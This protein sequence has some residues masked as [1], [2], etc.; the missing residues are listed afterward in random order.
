MITRDELQ[1]VNGLRHDRDNLDSLLRSFES[2]YVKAEVGIVCINSASKNNT[3]P[4]DDA[5]FFHNEMKHIVTKLNKLAL[6]ELKH[7]LAKVELE[8]AK[9]IGDSA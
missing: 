8:I 6:K 9:Y 1:K 5:K 7:E 4:S 3:Q 2:E